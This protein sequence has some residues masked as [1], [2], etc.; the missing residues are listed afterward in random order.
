MKTICNEPVRVKEHISMNSVKGTIFAKEYIDESE[1]KIVK[2]LQK[3]GATNVF[4]PTRREFDQFKP[5]G[6][7]ILTFESKILPTDVRLGFG[8]Y[9]VREY[10][11]NPR[12]CYNCFRY[13]HGTKHCRDTSTLCKRCGKIDHTSEICIENLKC[14]NCGERHEATSRECLHYITEKQILTTHVRNKIT[15]REAKIAIID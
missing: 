6:V 9:K 4:K 13:G 10:I 8:K 3:F 2:H 12:Q 5:T 11:P 1:I 14:V 7:M 15:Y